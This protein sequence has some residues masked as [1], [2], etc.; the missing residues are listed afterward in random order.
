MAVADGDQTVGRWQLH[1]RMLL[2]A[3]KEFEPA[4]VR[5]F[6]NLR[7]NIFIPLVKRLQKGETGLHCSH[8]H[9]RQSFYIIINI[10]TT[11]GY[12]YI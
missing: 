2:S 3:G 8:L 4:T 11:T 6:L 1:F 5:V 12:I 10:N 9:C 7:Q